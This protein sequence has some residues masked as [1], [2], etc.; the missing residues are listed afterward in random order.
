MAGPLP[1]T[2]TAVILYISRWVGGGGGVSDKKGNWK[3][4]KREDEDLYGDEENKGKKNGTIVALSL[5]RRPT[6]RPDDG[7]RARNRKKWE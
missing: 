2:L 4:D 5:R 3:R 7:V 6:R 1:L